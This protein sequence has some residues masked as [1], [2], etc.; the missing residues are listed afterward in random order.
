MKPEKTNIG[1]IGGVHCDPLSVFYEFVN[2]KKA[3]R[4]EQG[5][6]FVH[7]VQSFAVE[8]AA[9]PELV[10]QIAKEFIERSKILTGY[11]IAYATHTDRNSIHTHFVLNTVNMD[12]GKKWKFDS[13]NLKAMKDLSDELCKEHGLHVL[14]Q[15]FRSMNDEKAY[16]N[17]KRDNSYINEMGLAVKKCMEISIS[18]K[19]FQHNMSKLGYS[20]IWY[21]NRS[22]FTIKPPVGLPCR[23]IRLIP[24]EDFTKEMVIAKLNQNKQNAEMAKIYKQEQF[25]K[26]THKEIFMTALSMLSHNDVNINGRMS[27]LP[28]TKL[29]KQSYKE[30]IIQE[31]KGHGLEWTH[32]EYEI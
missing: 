1:L 21:E 17:N 9:T 31:Q 8:D 27:A 23:N 13:K 32:E 19:H 24:K 29:E 3:N 2:V 16:Y 15:K 14:P 5:R 28:F 22:T 7:F 10:N 6:Q 26:N 25:I 20:V 4:K 18:I 30:Q 12:T 11:Q